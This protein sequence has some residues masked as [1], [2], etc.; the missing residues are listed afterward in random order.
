MERVAG[1][2]G[3]HGHERDRVATKERLTASH[4]TAHLT[5]ESVTPA[6]GHAPAPANSGVPSRA[7]EDTPLS[8]EE[9]YDEVRQMIALGKKNGYLLYDDVNERLPSAI[10]S[11]DELDDLFETFGSAGIEVIDS[12]QKYRRDENALDRIAEGAEELELD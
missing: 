10:T 8:I 12:D 11:S 3:L 9:Q 7:S 5:A 1:T 4:R 6:R 2:A